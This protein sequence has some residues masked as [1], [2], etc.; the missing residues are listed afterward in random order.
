MMTDSSARS[1]EINGRFDNDLNIKYYYDTVRKKYKT[2]LLFKIYKTGNRN[3]LGNK[4]TLLRFCIIP[5]KS[6]Y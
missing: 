5:M 2:G 6:T 1:G 3:A 4:L